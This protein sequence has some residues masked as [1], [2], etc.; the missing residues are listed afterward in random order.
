[1]ETANRATERFVTLDDEVIA[2]WVPIRDDVSHDVKNIEN[3]VTRQTQASTDL[4]VLHS[5]NDVSNTEI[6]SV[7]GFTDSVPAS[8]H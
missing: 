5:A 8:G 3:A 6:A 4:L 2:E 7:K 1:M